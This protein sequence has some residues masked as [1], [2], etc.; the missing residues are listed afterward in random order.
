MSGLDAKGSGRLFLP[1]QPIL[2]LRVAAVKL[3]RYEEM[4]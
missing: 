4:K 3:N 2:R 1:F